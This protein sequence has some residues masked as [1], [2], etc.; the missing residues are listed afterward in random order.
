MNKTS[1]SQIVEMYK[2]FQAHLTSD[3]GGNCWYKEDW[4]DTRVAETI[5]CT[6]AAVGSCRRELYGDL[7]PSASIE[8]RLAALEALV[9]NE[10][11][12][13]RALIEMNRARIERLEARDA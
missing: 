11:A 6:R 4:D 10:L 1:R 5:G 12:T 13:C 8:D 3:G 7:Q 9:K 2:L